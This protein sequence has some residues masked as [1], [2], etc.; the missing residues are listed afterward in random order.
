MSMKVIRWVVAAA[1]VL[2]LGAV[3]FGQGPRG[4]MGVQLDP[5]PL[6]ELLT[7]HL[8][9]DPN[10]GI[11]I[12]NIS[13]DGPADKVGLDRD[14]IIVKLNGKKVSEADAFVAAVREL[15]LRSRVTLEVIHLGKSRTVEFEL[16]LAQGE[17]EWKYPVE[18]QMEF[19]WGPGRVF[20]LAPN[21]DNWVEIP[22]ENMP[23]VQN[24][25]KQ[26][27]SERY[28]YH[29]VT[30][31]ED[32]TIEI[33]GD[34][35]DDNTPIVV[36]S[37]AADYKTTVGTI[38]SLPEKYRAAARESVENARKSAS[39]RV[40]LGGR[41]A[42]PEPPDAQ[43]YRQYFDNMMP[44]GFDSNGLA[45]RRDRLI[46]ELQSKLDRVQRRLEQMENHL[47]TPGRSEKITPATPEPNSAAQNSSKPPEKPKTLNGNPI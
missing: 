1:A 10:E 20:R 13:K 42:F 22:F 19:S 24:S 30:D 26:F 37:G 14:D 29:H 18:A 46:E 23:D 43:M 16:G 34:P 5:T 40:R 39:Q 7:K 6:P 36:Q 35:K 3:S 32:Y 45:D 41:F 38:D 25:I 8:G 17:T 47:G 2:A 27:F 44:R 12:L 21:G 15:P 11:R 4:F 33:K 9:L 31:G 28:L